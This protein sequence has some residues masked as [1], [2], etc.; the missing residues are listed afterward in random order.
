[1]REQ[2]RHAFTLIELLVVIAIIA[3][4][5]GILLP[6]LGRARDTAKRTASGS[7]LRQHGI[8]VAL[9][10]AGNRDRLPSR[11]PYDFDLEGVTNP[12]HNQP[13]APGPGPLNVDVDNFVTDTGVVYRMPLDDPGDQWE[14]LLM[15]YNNYYNGTIFEETFWA[16]ADDVGRAFFEDEFTPS[17]TEWVRLQPWTPPSYA[18]S[19]VNLWSGQ[20]WKSGRNDAA[21]DSP[22]SAKVGRVGDVVYPSLKVAF[23]ERGWFNNNTV[24][25]PTLF[26]NEPDSEPG[27]V[28]FDGS[29][30][31]VQMGSLRA[32]M[33]TRSGPFSSHIWINEQ[34]AFFQS[35]QDGIRGRDL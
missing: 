9:Q 4:L 3:L 14:H 28:T 23:H 32:N 1:M 2:R 21:P 29:V 33:G 7:N 5:I 15:L 31:F 27:V 6:S 26:W 20:T 24:G 22:A 11:A 18:Y 13:R 17:T 35:T 30:T 25:D 12:F 10:A 19:Q 34:P 16:P 8:F